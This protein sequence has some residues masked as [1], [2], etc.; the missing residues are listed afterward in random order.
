MRNPPFTC[1]RAEPE[2]AAEIALIHVSSWHSAYRGL[3][4]EELLAGLSIDVRRSGWAQILNAQD[5]QAMTIVVEHD[6][7]MVG[8][9]HAGRAREV[10]PSL[11][12][13]EILRRFVG[14]VV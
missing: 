6:G 10:D 8:F 5:P 7:Q 12:W 9:C 1:R 11:N 4:P 13:G 2:D 3:L 14:I